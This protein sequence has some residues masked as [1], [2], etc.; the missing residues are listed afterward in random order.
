M[1]RRILFTIALVSITAFGI[2]AQNDAPPLVTDRPD[3]TESAAIVAKGK[4]QLESG[5]LYEKDHTEWLEMENYIYNSTL[6]RY[7]L[8]ENTELRVGMEYR[9]QRFSPE[10]NSE[11]TFT[12]LSPLYTGLKVKVAEEQGFR[13]EM[14]LLGSLTWPATADEDLKPRYV[15]PSLRMTFA[16]TLSDNLSLGY[17]LGA[18][19]DGH[20][21]EASYYYSLA[22][23]I[24]VTEKL[25]AFLESYG[26]LYEDDKPRHKA[27]AGFTYLVS[28][29]FQLDV[30]GGIGLSDTATDFYTSVGLSYR[31]PE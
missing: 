3:Q 4:L 21:P 7:G 13:P 25:G 11:L 10:S 12:G 26:L 31:F 15:S 17:N 29:N 5:F 2:K 30:S 14:A 28:N 9:D 23:G 22:F 19:W 8:T 1:N 27:D 6:L 18:E 20:N 16:H 24:G